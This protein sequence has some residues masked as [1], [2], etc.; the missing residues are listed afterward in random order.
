MPH[1]T[2]E[3]HDVDPA[4]AGRA[5]QVLLDRHLHWDVLVDHVA[6]IYD[7]GSRQELRLRFDLRG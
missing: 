2:L 4:T 3:E 5:V 7:T 6:L 1:V